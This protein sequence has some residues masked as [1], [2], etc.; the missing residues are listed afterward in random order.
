MSNEAM[1]GRTVLIT[2]GT[3]G[4]G[5][6]TGLAFGALGARVALTY[7]WGAHDVDELLAAYREVGASEPL[8][9]EADTSKDEHTEAAIEALAAA[10]WT[11][12]DALINNVAFAALIEKIDDY[13]ARALEQSVRYSAWPIVA[14]PRA[15]FRRMGV[16]P[17]YLVGVSSQGT[18]G[19][20][21][22]YDV[23]AAAKAVLES[24]V[25][26]LGHR[27][28][29]VG[30]RVNA[31]RPRWVDTRSLARTVGA[32]FPEFVARWPQRGQ[33]VTPAEVADVIVALCSGWL[34]GMTGQVIDIDHGNAF[35]DNL[36]RLYAA[37]L[38][39]TQTRTGKEQ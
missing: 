39:Q 28:A 19:F 4:I 10:G 23:A 37:H 7:N 14:Y 26:Y 20:H 33:F 22:N 9:I 11:R 1:R 13:D 16:W 29:P 8:L 18:T 21:V 6:A 35:S 12:V 15:V 5:R 30:T 17:S 27:L 24:L 32:G 34:D 36:M 38:D 2:G 31:V 25:R 3:A